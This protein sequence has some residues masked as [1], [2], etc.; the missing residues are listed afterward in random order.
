MVAGHEFDQST[1]WNSS[2]PGNWEEG[3]DWKKGGYPDRI[4][5]LDIIKAADGADTFDGRVMGLD[6]CNAVKPCPLHYVCNSAKN[7]ML[8]QLESKTLGDLFQDPKAALRSQIPMLAAMA[9]F[10]LLSL[11]RLKQPMERRASAM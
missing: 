10:S 1:R 4:S 9:L 11:W 2:F 7:E 6:E 3:W 8:D 5:L